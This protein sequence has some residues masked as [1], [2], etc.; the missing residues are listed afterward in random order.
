[1]GAKIS[2]KWSYT[3]ELPKYIF[4]YWSLDDFY[5]LLIMHK[6]YVFFYVN[7]YVD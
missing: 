3:F 5:F 4:I 7:K 6:I 2:K 1:M